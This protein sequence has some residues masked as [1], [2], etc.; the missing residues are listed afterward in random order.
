[1]DARLVVEET[2]SVAAGTPSPV[3][4][5]AT[6]STGTAANNGALAVAPPPPPPSAPQNPSSIVVVASPSGNHHQQQQQQQT[7]AA[8]PRILSRNVNG[9]R[10]SI[11]RIS[12]YLPGLLASLPLKWTIFFEPLTFRTEERVTRMRFRGFTF[13]LG[14]RY[15]ID[16]ARKLTRVRVPIACLPSIRVNVN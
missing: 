7:A 12:V 4:S 3:P 16:F 14:T 13:D 9:T 5:S 8:L 1:M 15:T 2:S 11:Y 6:P 10:K